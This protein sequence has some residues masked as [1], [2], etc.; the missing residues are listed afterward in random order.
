MI[1]VADFVKDIKDGILVI[2][3]KEE[4]PCPKCGGA[5]FM[6]GRCRRKLRTTVDQVLRLSLRVME[7]EECGITHR[8]LPAGIVPYK[9][10]S[11]DAIAAMKEAP[12]SSAAEPSVRVRVLA[13]LL[14]F[15][16]Y[17]EHIFE[18][19]LQQGYN[20]THPVGSS[21]GR[22]LKQFV[23]LVVNSGNWVQHRSVIRC[24]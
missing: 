15:L 17:A 21:L 23:R 19:L 3:G 13:W 16:E 8:E 9:R 24:L 5:L 22:R 2:T 6:H 4:V 1:S 20:L 10:N 7:C 18:S 11:A 12:E 14:W